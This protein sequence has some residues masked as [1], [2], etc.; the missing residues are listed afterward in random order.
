MFKRKHLGMRPPEAKTVYLTPNKKLLQHG[1]LQETG[2]FAQ[3]PNE[4]AMRYNTVYGNGA[5]INGR[6]GGGANT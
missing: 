3:S 1:N 6:N 4:I 2:G 5:M